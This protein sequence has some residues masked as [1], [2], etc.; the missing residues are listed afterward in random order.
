MDKTTAHKTM[1]RHIQRCRRRPPLTMPPSVLGRTLSFTVRYTQ[2]KYTSF[3]VQKYLEGC[4]VVCLNRTV[5]VVLCACLLSFYAV[6][7]M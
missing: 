1:V 3:F 2:L 6:S 7:I 5:F 4:I